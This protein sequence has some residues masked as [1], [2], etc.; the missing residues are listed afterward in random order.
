MPSYDYVIVGA[1]FT[2]ATFAHFA[3]KMGKKCI[4]IDKR[5]HI[6]GNSYT[7]SVSGIQVHKYGPHIF[8]TSNDEIWNFVNQFVTFNNFVNRPKVIYQQ[9]I[10]SFPINMMT[11]YQLWGVQNPSDAKKMLVEA[12][13]PYK[14][15]YSSPGNME[16]W[17]LCQVGK[18][19]YETFIYGYT[20]KQWKRTPDKLPASILKRVP[21][22]LTWDDNYYEDKHQGIPIGGYTKIFEGMLEGIEVQLGVDFLKEKGL[23]ETLGHRIIYT[24]PVDE[25]YNYE[26]GKL[27]YRTLNFDTKVQSGDCQ[28]NAIFNYSDLTVPWTRIIE[29]K[30]FDIS[31]KSENT[32]ITTEIPA[33]WVE[34]STPYYPINDD[35]NNSLYERYAKII[36]PKYIIAGRLG[37]YKYFDMHQAIGSAIQLHKNLNLNIKLHPSIQLKIMCYIEKI[38]QMKKRSLL[39]FLQVSLTSHSL[40]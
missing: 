3:T 13:S 8:H 24:G 30:H 28:G 31:Q 17:A 11:L 35:V 6:G 12:T 5:E 39:T 37:R 34:N 14:D 2:G 32:V 4:V 25:L 26:F 40:N 21:I 20:T 36:N 1:G 23:F 38:C 19:I 33:E 7:E 18:E 10:F 9:K 29:H 22:R 15:K 27:E 16:E